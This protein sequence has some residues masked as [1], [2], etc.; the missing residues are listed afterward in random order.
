MTSETAQRRDHGHHENRCS[1]DRSR[2]PRPGLR[3]A[4]NRLGWRGQNL[5]D[6]EPSHPDIGHALSRILHETSANELRD[7][8]RKLPGKKGQV[9]LLI[10]HGRE[11]VGDVIPVERAPARQ[12]LVETASIRPDIHPFV[13]RLAAGLLWAHIGCGT[14]DHAEP[15]AFGQGR[16]LRAAVPGPLRFGFDEFR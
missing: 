5:R 15:C 6:L 8:R 7:G 14:Q 13:D 16:R 12:G 11:H 3:R 4:F 2:E 10:H 9:R 1:K